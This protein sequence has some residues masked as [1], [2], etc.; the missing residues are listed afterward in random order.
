LTS[1]RGSVICSPA[2]NA[3]ANQRVPAWPPRER[4]Q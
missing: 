2:S 3:P 4:R 1:C